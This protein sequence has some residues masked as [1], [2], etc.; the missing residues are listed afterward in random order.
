MGGANIMMMGL[1]N[2]GFVGSLVT[3]VTLATPTINTLS[4]TIDTSRNRTTISIPVVNND[5]ESGVTISASFNANMS[6]AVST[7]ASSGQTVTL[8]LIHNTNGVEPGTVTVYAR[9]TK[10]GFTNSTT[11]SRT[12]TLSICSIT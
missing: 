8:S 11:T 2:V 5:T 6:S 3:I 4:C 7:T 12:Q 1:R 10:T 9:A